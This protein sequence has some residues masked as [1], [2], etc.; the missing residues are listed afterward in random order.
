MF[1]LR[2]T[3]VVEG[4]RVIDRVLVDLEHRITDVRPA[5]PLVIARFRAIVAKAFATE[6]ASTGAK[7]AP[8][9]ASTVADRRRHHFAPHP[10]LERTGTLRRSLTTDQGLGFVQETATSLTIG[11]NAK[12]FPFHQ[13]RRPRTRLPRRAPVE[14]T[15][16]DRTELVRPIAE[17]VLG[18]NPTTP[19]PLGRSQ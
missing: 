1:T 5:W 19:R 16:T 9:A 12:S 17:Y 7:W 3:G 11:S 18:T 15:S 13:S 4:Q 10:I 6:G 8:L 2:I 14:L